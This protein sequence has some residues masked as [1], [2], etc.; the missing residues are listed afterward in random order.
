MALNSNNFFQLFLD[1]A[2]LTHNVNTPLQLSHVT[3]WAYR[4]DT[5]FPNTVANNVGNYA[6]ERNCVKQSANYTSLMDNELTHSKLF[7][8]LT[9]DIISQSQNSSTAKGL[10]S[11]SNPAT[12]LGLS[13]AGRDT[14][15]YINEN[16]PNVDKFC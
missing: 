12:I 14:L 11:Q 4:D 7:F 1:N 3:P 2:P 13:F 15:R 16:N 10:Q 6:G 9:P 8:V 5:Y